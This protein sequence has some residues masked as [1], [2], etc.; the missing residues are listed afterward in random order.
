MQNL[1]KMRLFAKPLL[2]IQ[3]IDVILRA[4]QKMRRD[5]FRQLVGNYSVCYLF[6]SNELMTATGLL[7]EA[8]FLDCCCCHHPPKPIDFV[9]FDRNSLQSLVLHHNLTFSD[10][11]S[12]EMS[13]V[14][15]PQEKVTN[16]ASQIIVTPIC[17]HQTSCKI[18]LC[19]YG[20]LSQFYNL[21]GWASLRRCQS[22]Q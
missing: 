9:S 20:K 19:Y 16:F 1:R 18:I 15:T 10:S 12:T 21:A 11:I 2:R 13:R 4:Y 22:T 17:N 5:R 3:P 6:W 7:F 14:E 8:C